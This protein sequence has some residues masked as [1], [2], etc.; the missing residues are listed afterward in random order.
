[1]TC[2][3]DVL[4]RVNEGVNEMKAECGNLW[5]SHIGRVLGV[6]VDEPSLRIRK[7]GNVFWSAALN[8]GAGKVAH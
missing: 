8:H 4:G 7:V 1:M 3:G 5:D 6:K 2:P